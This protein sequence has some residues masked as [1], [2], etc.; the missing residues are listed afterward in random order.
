MNPFSHKYGETAT[1]KKHELSMNRVSSKMAILKFGNNQ[2]ED[3]F[4]VAQKVDCEKYDENVSVNRYIVSC[5]IDAYLLPGTVR[6][7]F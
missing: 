6:T 3:L 4:D 5:L 7:L 2:I 1:N